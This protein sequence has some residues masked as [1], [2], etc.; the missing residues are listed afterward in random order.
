MTGSKAERG[1]VLTDLTM[2]TPCPT[3]LTVPVVIERV[4][5]LGE[6]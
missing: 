1:S 3:N 2:D 4:R 5:A 6:D